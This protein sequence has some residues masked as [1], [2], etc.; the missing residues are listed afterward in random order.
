MKTRIPN[1]KKVKPTG[2]LVDFRQTFW[3]HN[4][5]TSTIDDRVLQGHSWNRGRLAA[6]DHVRWIT[7]YGYAE[8]RVVLADPVFGVDDMTR[9]T[10]RVV[11]RFGRDGKQFWLESRSR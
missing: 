10:V 7:A 5:E 4:F 8:G 1:L 2:R 11:A 3:G 9:I 6:G